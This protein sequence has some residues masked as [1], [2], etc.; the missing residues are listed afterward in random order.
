[1]KDVF[2]IL[3]EFL[4]PPAA[5]ERPSCQSLSAELSASSQAQPACVKPA[6]AGQSSQPHSSPAASSHTWCHPWPRLR[7]RWV[8]AEEEALAVGAEQ[9]LLSSTGGH[10]PSDTELAEG[11][12][13]TRRLIFP[14]STWCHGARAG[15]KA[16]FQQCCQQ[17]GGDHRAKAP[18]NNAL[19]L[20]SAQ[21]SEGT[22]KQRGSASSTSAKRTARLPHRQHSTQQSTWRRLWEPS[23]GKGR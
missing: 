21:R 6:G 7:L 14:G 13:G 8:V 10:D 5:A 17:A 20:S 3:R 11:T 23:T 18:P 19:T 12:P 22:N 4:T 15:P 16:P 1:M 9:L 2:C